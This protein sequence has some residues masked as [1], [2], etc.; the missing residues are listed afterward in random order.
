MALTV[1]MDGTTLLYP[2]YRFYKTI[3][4]TIYSL[5]IVIIS[6]SIH[7]TAGKQ[8]AVFGA[9]NRGRYCES[10]DVFLSKKTLM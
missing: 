9:Q 8:I 10:L 7:W 5:K 2:L 3:D 1:V 4:S 6:C